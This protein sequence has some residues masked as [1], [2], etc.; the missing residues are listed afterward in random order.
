MTASA[1]QGGRE[2]R[3]AGLWRACWAGPSG[4]ESPLLG[5]SVRPSGNSSVSPGS[6]GCG[7]GQDL[8][9]LQP[10]RPGPAQGACLCCRGLP[11]QAFEYIRYNKGIMGEDSYPYEGQVI[12]DSCGFTAAACGAARHLPPRPRER[13]RGPSH[14]DRPLVRSSSPRLAGAHPHTSPAASRPPVAPVLWVPSC[15]CTERPAST[16][17]PIRQHCPCGHSHADRAFQHLHPLCPRPVHGPV[18]PPQIHGSTSI[19]PC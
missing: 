6:V 13:Q 16:A 19:S 2:G 17:L 8:Q 18:S 12:R 1:P 14:Q 11:S 9:P 4:G 7:P 15:R 3:Q 10:P 5:G